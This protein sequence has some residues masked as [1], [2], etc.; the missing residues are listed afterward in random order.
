MVD[1]FLSEHELINGSDDCTP[2]FFLSIND[3]FELFMVWSVNI[4]P[5]TTTTREGVKKGLL[6]EGFDCGSIFAGPICTW[7]NA[8]SLFL[9]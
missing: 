8:C 7:M 2:F 1:L 6:P 3:P 4:H 5:S 9:D